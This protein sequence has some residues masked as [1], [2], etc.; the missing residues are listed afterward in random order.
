MQKWI[1]DEFKHCGVDYSQIQQA[2]KYDDRHR[3]FRDFEKEFKGMIDF[4]EL[5][6]ASDMTLIDLGCG[7]GAATI[8]AADCF[9]AVYAVDVSDVMIEQAK[10]KLGP[11][12]RNVHFV[13]AGFLSYNHKGEQ[14]DIVMSKAAF[15]HLP[16]FWKQIALLRMNKMLKLGGLLYIHDV[17]FHFVPQE[18]ADRIEAWISGLGESAGEAF[19]REIETHIR[20]EFSTFHWILAGMIERAGFAIEKHKSDDAFLAEYACRKIREFDHYETE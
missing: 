6:D 8:F 19:I 17:V 12:D 5:Q 1:Y 20:D 10:K 18:Y 9:K 7:T 15:H 3:K 13:N 14:A 2:E 4:L 11:A 16:D